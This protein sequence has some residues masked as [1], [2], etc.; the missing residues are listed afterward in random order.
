MRALL[1]TAVRGLTLSLLLSLPVAHPPIASAEAD[2]P[3]DIKAPDVIHWNIAA[4]TVDADGKVNAIVYLTTNQGFSL[5]KHKTTVTNEQGY[6]LESLKDPGTV[7]ITDPVTKEPTYVYKEGEFIFTFKPTDS[8]TQAPQNFGISIRYIACTEQICLFPYTQKLSIQLVSGSALIASQ[9]D[10]SIGESTG[11]DLGINTDESEDFESRLAQK[12]K[13]S[14]SF[15]L[16][17]LIVFLG[18]ILTNLT[19]CVF[20]MIPITMR[21]LSGQHKS[22]YHAATAYAGGILVTYTLLG[23][24]AAST[25]GFFGALLANKWFNLFF[26]VMMFLFGITM[27]G[28]GNLSKLQLL[29]NRFGAGNPSLKNA[30]LM[31]SGAGLVAAPCTGP[32]LAVL[33]AITAES[34]EL[35]RGSFLMFIYSL[36]FAIPYVFLGGASAKVQRIKAPPQVQLGVKLLFAGVMF[37]LGLYY[38]RIPFYSFLESMNHVWYP[39]FLVTLPLG[40]IGLAVILFNE[41]LHNNK[42]LQI[43][44]PMLIAL[45]IF[46]FIRYEYV[47]GKEAVKAAGL[48]WYKD[49][50]LALDMALK[51]N[52]PILV[53]GWAEWCEACKKMDVTTFAE[54]AVIEELKANW[55]ILKFDLTEVNDVNDDITE[56]YEL[57]SLPTLIMVPSSGSL[58]QKEAVAGYVNG[59]TLL[60]RMKAFHKKQR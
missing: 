31:G 11:N 24:I 50:S 48:V 6:Q 22:P 49:E 29:G 32:I 36:G 46:S 8:T 25:G 56:R 59:A 21:I 15:W 54:P 17:L 7:E 40:L 33:L 53:D 13:D 12:L 2:A 44:P 30:F 45:A 37:A 35:V 60:K 23:I 3:K 27:L 1:W 20:P 19:P 47:A 4:A 28:F 14:K 43:I 51:E 42:V 34:G 38:L 52:K 18:G 16:I 5:Y 57:S 58:A 9:T 10:A 55:I 41:K 39:V 26:A